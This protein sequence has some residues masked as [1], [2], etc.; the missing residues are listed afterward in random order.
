M[1]LS[2]K[3]DSMMSM[4]RSQINRVIGSA[5]SDR[6]IPEIQNMMGLPSSGQKDTDSGTSTNNQENSEEKSWLKIKV[7]KKDSRSAFDLRDNGNLSSCNYCSQLFLDIG[8]VIHCD[9]V[10]RN[11]LPNANLVKIVSSI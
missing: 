2:Q 1:R 8:A 5:I 4:M 10:L 9:V 7:T 3:M 11:Q 6:V